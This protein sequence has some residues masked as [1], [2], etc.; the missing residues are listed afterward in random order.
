MWQLFDKLRKEQPDFE[1][2]IL[3]VCGD[4]LQPELGIA[5]DD[6]RML[7]EEINVVFHSAAT[8]KFDETL[9]LDLTCCIVE[10]GQ[11]DLTFSIVEVGQLDLTFSI[12]EVGQLDLTYS[13]VEVGQL[14]LT[15][16]IEISGG[17]TF[18]ECVLIVCYGV[19]DISFYQ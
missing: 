1:Q 16:S 14:D 13:I 2:K 10:V 4:I 11:L 6:R 17:G 18:A 7:E 15:F 3:P 9:R 12:A 8:V 19:M 5:E